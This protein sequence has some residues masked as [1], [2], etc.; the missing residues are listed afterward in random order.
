V[1]LCSVDM[2]IYKE[3]RRDESS[4]PHSILRLTS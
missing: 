4:T 2:A 3:R 1:I